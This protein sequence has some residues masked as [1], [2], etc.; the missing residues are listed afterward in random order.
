M[1]LARLCN[2]CLQ[3]YLRYTHLTYV[4]MYTVCTRDFCLSVCT[5]LCL[6]VPELVSGTPSAHCLLAV[7]L[8]QDEL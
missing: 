4:R 8:L 1:E 5:Y 7:D 6:G 2:Y 3:N